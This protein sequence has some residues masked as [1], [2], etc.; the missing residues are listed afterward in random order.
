MIPKIIHY[1]WLSNDEIP[2]DM[3]QYIN[4]WKKLLPDYKFIKWNFDIFDKG[5]CPW[6]SEAFD[7]K[8]YAFA[9]DYIR[10][11]AV[12][13]YG[14]IY[15]DMDIE[16]VKP[17]DDLLD[18]D[19]MIA[20]ENNR[21]YG[22]EAGCFGA[23]K[24]NTFIKKCLDYYNGKHFSLEQNSTDSLTPLPMIMQKVLDDSDYKFSIRNCDSFTAKSFD[25]GKIMR[26]ENT[27]AIHHFAGSWKTD[28]EK[29]I[30]ALTQVYSRVFGRRIGHNLAEFKIISENKGISNGIKHIVKKFIK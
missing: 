20:Y 28:E 8:K 17:F 3:Q 12:Y 6:V 10:L 9:A 2:E 13:N 23:E 1:C 24:N 11:Y 22:L 15:M 7:A 21:K 4:G 30:V 29:R 27:Y 19:V 14:G 5:S 26:T 18:T 25:T 16:V